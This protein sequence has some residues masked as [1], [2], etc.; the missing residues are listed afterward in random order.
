MEWNSKVGVGSLVSP[1]GP[2]SITA[3]GGVVSICHSKEAGEPSALPAKSIARTSK[4][5]APSASPVYSLGEVQL[6]QAPASVESRRHSKE[7]R[8]A[9]ARGLLP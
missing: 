3:V 8:P 6:V 9:A 2:A 5:W 4:T 7:A 1:E